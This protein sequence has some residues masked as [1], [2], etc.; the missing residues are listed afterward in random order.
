M[1][2]PEVV[3]T[4]NT[5]DNEGRE[6][7]VEENESTGPWDEYRGSGAI[8]GGGSGASIALLLRHSRCWCSC[9]RRDKIR[10]SH[11]LLGNKNDTQKEKQGNNKGRQ[12]KEKELLKF[13]THLR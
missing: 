11:G 6:K 13:S 1:C 8:A 2:S 10:H 9:V 5:G 3:L 12:R 7:S 4:R